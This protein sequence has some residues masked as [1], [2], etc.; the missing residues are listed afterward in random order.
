MFIKQIS[1]FIENK[2]GRL[3]SLANALGEAGVDLV[4]LS[5]ADTTNYGIL[6]CIVRNADE[7]LQIIQNAGFTAKTTEV[8]AVEV[9]DKPGGLAHILNIM[10]EKGINVEYLYS[11]ANSPV[12]KALI[13]FKVDDTQKTIEALEAQGV[14][15]LLQEDIANL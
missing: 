8:I 9:E 4:A 11:F 3:A 1:V 2:Q 6:R 7:A 12:K 10:C 13:I 15:T 5:I 14:R